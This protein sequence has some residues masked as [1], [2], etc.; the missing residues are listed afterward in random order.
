MVGK[1]QSK[2]AAAFH[3]FPGFCSQFEVGSIVVA[4]EK[5]ERESAANRCSTTTALG[6]DP[7]VWSNYGSCFK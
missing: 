5:A 4:R 6:G 1:K 3:S 7:N 2:I